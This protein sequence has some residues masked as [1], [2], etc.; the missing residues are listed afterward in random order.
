MELTKELAHELFYEVDGIL[1]WKPK[2]NT[3]KRSKFFNTL[4]ANKE[5]GG[6]DRKGYRRVV[7][8]QGCKTT[9]VHRVIFLMHHGYLPEVIDHING[10]PADNRIDNLRAATRQTNNQ[11]S[12]LARHNT[13]GVKGVSYSK[14][15]RYWRC[16]LSFNNKTKEV[17]GFKTI[18]DAADFMDLWRSLAHGEFANN[19]IRSEA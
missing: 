11:N 4:Y 6:F 10:M 7:Y 17:A 1:F 2:P 15:D 18:E 5:A 14:K 16:S 9:G 19:G 8:K 12:R 3:V 13:S